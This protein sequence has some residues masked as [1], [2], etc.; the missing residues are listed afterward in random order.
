M[1]NAYNLRIPTT[2][3][4]LG[5][6][7]LWGLMAKNPWLPDYIFNTLPHAFQPPIAPLWLN[8]RLISYQ[9]R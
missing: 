7:V 6:S 1:P 4:T 2:L 3:Q 9:N 8:T 5:M